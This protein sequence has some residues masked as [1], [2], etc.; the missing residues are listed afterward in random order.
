MLLNVS[1]SSARAPLSSLGHPSGILPVLRIVL[2]SAEPLSKA[3]VKRGQSQ[4]GEYFDEEVASRRCARLNRILRRIEVT[5]RYERGSIIVTSNLPFDEW[6][7]VFSSERL[8]G[9]ILDR[10]IHHFHILEKTGKGF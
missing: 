7:E 4:R 6:T 9:A 10:L 8:A 1:S 2:W 3:V 5:Q